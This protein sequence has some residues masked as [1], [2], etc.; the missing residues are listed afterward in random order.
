MTEN[1]L[2]TSDQ[3]T[4]VPPF[5]LSVAL[6]SSSAPG[7]M[8]V[9]VA[10]WMELSFPCQLPPTS[11][12]PPPVAPEAVRCAPEVTSTLSPVATISPPLLPDEEASSVPEMVVIPSFASRIIWPAL[13]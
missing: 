13:C 3:A 12:S 10:W 9:P 1:G 8:T 11:T 5:P 4:T 2:V 7:S 6:A